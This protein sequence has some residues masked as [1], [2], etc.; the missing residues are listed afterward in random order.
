MDLQKKI[1]VVTK[2]SEEVVT[3]EELRV[4]LETNAKP[5]AYWGFE[6]SGQ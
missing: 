4:L 2:N 3:Q 6:C 1:D 5:K